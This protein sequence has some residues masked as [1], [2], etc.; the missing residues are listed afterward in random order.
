MPIYYLTLN[1]NKVGSKCRY[2]D[3]L[4]SSA[5][6]LILAEFNRR[7]PSIKC[8]SF[9]YR[10]CLIPALISIF[11]HWEQGG[12]VVYKVAPRVDTPWSAAWITAFCSA[13]IQTQVSS[14]S[15]DLSF[16]LSRSEHLLQ[17]PSSQFGI[18]WG[19]P[20][21]PVAMILLSCTKTAPT[22]LLMQFDLVATTSASCIKY[23][24]QFGLFI[25]PMWLIVSKC[26]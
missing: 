4:R 9:R 20:L 26:W 2:A 3:L 1:H 18:P 5:V 16:P 10:T 17:P 8:G 23:V 22:L 21:Y 24:F 25:R 7:I 19:V 15:P 14:R 12:M 11:A 13:W 6:E